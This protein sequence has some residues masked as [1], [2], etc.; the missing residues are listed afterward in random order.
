M[1]IEM[2]T[3]CCIFFN[4]LLIPFSP[5]FR[6]KFSFA[7]RTR[8]CSDWRMK[9]MQL[10]DK[11]SN[12]DRN[13]YVL[14]FSLIYLFSVLFISLMM[15]MLIS[16]VLQV[17]TVYLHECINNTPLKL[18]WHLI[19]FKSQ[20]KTCYWVSFLGLVSLTVGIIDNSL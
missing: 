15:I 8:L 16:Q 1:L 14:C 12:C 9:E 2:F 19:T 5:S 4:L 18:W 10:L 3:V 11:Q 6:L 13:W 17:K 7:C 20:L